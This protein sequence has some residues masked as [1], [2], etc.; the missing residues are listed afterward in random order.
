[1][2][3]PAVRDARR[4][5]RPAQL[6]TWQWAALAAAWVLAAAIGYFHTVAY[7]DYVDHLDRTALRG[8]SAAQTPTQRICPDADA[9]MWERNA[10]ALARGGQLRLRHT[11]ADNAPYGREVHWDS[12]LA[13]LLAGAGWLQHAV[14]GVPWPL[15]IERALAWFNLPLLLAGIVLLSIAATRWAGVVAGVF[16]TGAM[17]GNGDFYSGFAPDFVDHHGVLS[18]MVLGLVLGAAFMAGGLYD[19]TAPQARL[20]PHSPRLARR[21]AVFSAGC[22][23]VGMWV[24]APTLIPAIVLTALAGAAAVVLLGRS[25]DAQPVRLDPGVWR[26]WG[27][28]GAALTFG[29]YLLEYAPHHLAL[30]LEVNHPFYAAAWW[31]GGELMAQLAEWRRGGPRDAHARARAALAA[32]AILAAPAAIVLG[33][34]DVFVVFDPFVARLSRYV[35]E[36]FSTVK[37][38]R[39]YGAERL[40]TE[41]PMSMAAAGFAVAAGRRSRGADRAV[42]VLAAGVALALT[43]MAVAQIRWWPTA[44]AAQIAVIAVAIRSFAGA[45]P[46]W[47]PGLA[48]LLACL[49]L[50][51]YPAITRVARQYADNRRGAADRM[52]AFQPLYRDIAAILRIAQP[53]GRIVV[54]ASPN[55]SASIAYY[56]RFQAIGT[57]YWENLAGMKAAAEILAATSADEAR[58]LVRARGITHVVMLSEEHFLAEDFAL[59]HPGAPPEAWQESFGAALLTG[60][61]VPLWLEPIPYRIPDDAPARPERVVLYRVRFGPIGAEAAYDAATRALA[62]GDTATAAAKLDEALAAAPRAAEL[63]LAEA[64]LLLGTG[65]PRAAAE[66]V[67]RAAEFAAPA[68]RF[69]LCADAANGF[70]QAGALPEAAD[71]CRRALA[72]EFEPTIANNLVWL[73]ATCGDARVRNG[74]EALRLAERLAPDHPEFPFLSAHA[75]A[76]AECGRC[77][78]AAALSGQALERARGARNFAAANDESQ[79]LAAYRAGRAWRQ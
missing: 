7:R 50:G 47:R 70:R 79:H 56:G 67:A 21:A 41:V 62:A 54:L 29:F 51:F 57:L 20:A 24:S 15:G 38:V 33:G 14:T 3:S 19:D 30:R 23:A 63:W 42:V 36:G 43:G 55:A 45:R 4:D 48:A 40:W 59:L 78:E 22:G 69:A 44:A 6:P 76:L 61:D 39:L 66:A 12:G 74:A 16:V 25:T 46:A 73:L 52:D 1:M 13:W 5:Q 68:Q 31:G 53:H 35:S 77:A 32:L 34:A 17:V 26:R 2:P 72:F 11:D 27:Q 58:R 18:T 49:G 71:L 37:A 75:A 10:V 60:R 8:A 64:K 65:K 28:V 9:Q